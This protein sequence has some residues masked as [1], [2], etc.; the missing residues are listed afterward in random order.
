MK[1]LITVLVCYACAH[2][3]LAEMAEGLRH[4]ADAP[5]PGEF[6]R[7][8]QP[9]ARRAHRQYSLVVGTVAAVLGCLIV[10]WVG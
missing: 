3:R 1:Y 8:A 9:H 4:R 6:L 5:T 7:E 10:L 2:G